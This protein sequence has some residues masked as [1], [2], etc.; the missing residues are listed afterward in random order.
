MTCEVEYKGIGCERDVKWR[1]FT[2]TN[3]VEVFKSKDICATHKNTFVRK[4]ER[5][6]SKDML[7]LYFDLPYTLTQL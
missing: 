5:F 7:G 4:V 3:D 1:L 6:K 2:P